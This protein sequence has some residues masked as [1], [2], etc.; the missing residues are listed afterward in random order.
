MTDL[1]N[2]VSVMK[3]EKPQ[4]INSVEFCYHGLYRKISPVIRRKIER[5]FDM[6]KNNND[7]LEKLESVLR[8]GQEEP[9]SLLNQKLE[10]VFAVHNTKNILNRRK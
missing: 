8:E 3:Q 9:R 2:H 10:K 7:F 4:S 5:K 6:F 1:L